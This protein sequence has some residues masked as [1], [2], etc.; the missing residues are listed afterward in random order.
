MSNLPYDME[1]QETLLERYRVLRVLGRGGMGAVCLVEDLRLPGSRWAAKELVCHEKQMAP[2]MQA[3]FE[4]EASLLAQLRHPNLPT[5]VDFFSQEGKQYLIMEYIEGKTLQEII[6]HPES[7]YTEEEA[8][9][10]GRDVARALE[11]LH[12]QSPPIIFRD[13]K[14][15]NIMLAGDGVIK[16]IDFGLARRYDPRKKL[17][18]YLTISPGFTAPE[19]LQDTRQSEPRSD[20]YSWGATL[21]HLLTRTV[22]VFSY[23]LPSLTSLNPRISEEVEQIVLRC[24]K[25]DPSWR[26]QSARELLLDLEEV[27]RGARQK[28]RLRPPSRKASK[29]VPLLSDLLSR[30]TPRQSPV[31]RGPMFR[32][33]PEARMKDAGREALQEGDPEEACEI[34]T[35][36]LGGSPHD[37]EARILRENARIARERHSSIR[38]PFVAPFSTYGWD[39]VQVLCQGMALAQE[40]A[41]SGGG[42]GNRL[43]EIQLCDDR[44]NLTRTLEWGEKLA[45]DPQI[46]GFLGLC[47]DEQV[48]ALA[49]LLQKRKL[50]CISPVGT[51]P[52]SF[53]S[54]RYIFTVFDAFYPRIKTF[55]LYLTEGAEKSKA[56]RSPSEEAPPQ[57]FFP[58]G[59]LN[60]IGVIFDE[61]DEFTKFPAQLF[62]RYLKARIQVEVVPVLFKMIQTQDFSPQIQQIKEYRLDLLLF[63]GYK[64][65]QLALLKGGLERGG[66]SLPLLTVYLG[67]YQ[68]LLDLVGK[69]CSGIFMADYFHPDLQDQGVQEF[70]RKFQEAF[71]LTYP[72]S[73][74]VDGYNA[75]ALAIKAIQEGEGTRE[76]M[77]R[78]LESLGT[79]LPP[80]PG[81][82]GPIAPGLRGDIRSFYIISLE[83][84]SYRLASRGF[85]PSSL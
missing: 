79:S 15:G 9:R 68:T 26:Y 42:I 35:R 32:K 77:T 75:L 64:E 60:R 61:N 41:N 25:G 70:A 20:I 58:P 85:L 1:I 54:S 40:E 5:I 63:C 19:Q 78:Y 71:R 44:T 30:L 67:N 28:K 24:L 49:P 18:T 27:L 6:D 62:T 76:G 59:K 43:I 81:V 16:L 80:F 36:Y 69:G 29:G 3:L 23:D 7:P 31:D 10:W 22:P 4:R 39:Y 14:P 33:P 8:L 21:Y 55:V 17:D 52:R 83:D 13:L 56:E 84:G 74:A 45:G 38:I 50:P 48:M 82:G 51:H 34:L 37:G 65:F 11:Y 73:A 2:Y 46:V 72:S 57:T 53:L 66:V 47:T 12:G